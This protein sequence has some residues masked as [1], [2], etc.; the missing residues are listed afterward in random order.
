ML[1][2][3]SERL[4]VQP[5]TTWVRTYESQP[6]LVTT[7]GQVEPLP[8]PGGPEAPDVAA[9]VEQLSGVVMT[10]GEDG[11]TLVLGEVLLEGE[12]ASDTDVRAWLDSPDSSR[13]L[14]EGLDEP[15]AVWVPGVTQVGGVWFAVG[16]SRADLDRVGS[17]LALGRRRDLDAA[18]G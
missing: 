7:D 17:G 10:T 15:G 5:D 12:Q 18:D 3:D 11:S 1:W 8:W 9:L 13:R 14:V 4:A 6:H 16:G 2:T